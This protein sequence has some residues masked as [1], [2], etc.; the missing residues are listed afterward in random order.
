MLYYVSVFERIISFFNNFF[1]RRLSGRGEDIENI[2]F[3]EGRV[4]SERD[5][6]VAVYKDSEGNIYKFSPVCTHLGCLIN[7]DDEKKHW[8]CDCH[9]S[10]FSPKGEIL[11]GPA[12]I[13]LK[14][15][16]DKKKKYVV[17]ILMTEF[18]THDVKRFILE[19]PVGFEFIPGQATE[20]SINKEGWREE[21]RPFTFTSLNEEAVLEF[22][23]KGY[24]SH[25]GVTE[26][27]HKLA[28]GDELI[29]REPWGTINYEGEGT[30][31][32]GGAGITPFLSIFR[33]LNQKN[34]LEG[35]KLIFTNKTPEDVILEKELRHYFKDK[36]TF[37]VTQAEENVCSKYEEAYIDKDYLKDK[38]ADFSQ[39]FYVCGP[40]EFVKDI[41]SYLEELGASADSVVFEE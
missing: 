22:T 15:F 24:P 39:R 36:G 21:K 3:G 40:P 23:I 10:E 17:K 4:V 12:K 20:V 26:Q 34:K 13:S 19:K 7:W 8:V 29:L 30:F 18:I 31:I 16:S 1:L 35:N 41:K 37:I 6:K 14:E 25:N 9:G 28:S 11:S 2:P 38:I 27:L 5:K 32:A 33:S